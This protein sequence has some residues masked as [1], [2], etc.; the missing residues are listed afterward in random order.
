MLGSDYRELIVK[1]CDQQAKQY[2]ILIGGSLLTVLSAIP[3]FTAG[4]FPL[5][6]VSALLGFCTWYLY[7]AQNIEYEYVISGD[8]LVITKIINESKRK[9]LLTV[10]LMKFTA[11]GRLKEAPAIS[12]DQTL[13][14]ACAAQNGSTFYAEFDH[15]ALG[16]TRLLW[17]PNDD[18]LLYLTKHLPRPLGFRWESP[19]Q[20]AAES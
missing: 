13:V 3:A 6:L 17:T 4:L 20:T 7:T 9:P 1:K 14:L 8:E 11:F 16:R 2:G 12:N 10:S 18:I 5:L 15:D 19:A